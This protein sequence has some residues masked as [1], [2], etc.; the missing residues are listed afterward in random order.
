MTDAPSN[1]RESTSDADL[2]G[3]QLDGY[4]LIRRLARGAMA[5]VY[6]AHQE[7]LR[8]SVAVKVLKADLAKDA[9]YVK[10]FHNEAQAAASLVHANIVQI[11]SVG[12]ADGVHYIAQEYVQGQ[13][14]R[15]W[16]GRNGPADATAAVTIMRQVSAALQ[17]AAERGIVHRDIKPENIML[18]RTGEV[19]VADFGLARQTGDVAMNLTQIGVTMGTPLYMSPEQVEGRPLDPRSDLYSFGVTAYQMLSGMPPFRGETA[20]AIAV[21]HLKTPP[22]RIENLRPDLPPGLCRII[23]KLLAKDPQARYESAR[24]LLKDLHGLQL[25]G[26]AASWP[27]DASETSPEERNALASVGAA[28]ER[29]A[30]VMQ[31]SAQPVVSRRRLGMFSAALLLAFSAGGLAA[32]ALRAP[33]LL[34]PRA[35]TTVYKEKTAAD[36]FYHALSMPDDRQREAWLLSVPQYFNN[37]EDHTAMSRQYLAQLYLKEKR[38]AEALVTLEELATM[39]EQQFKRFKAFGLAG[40]AVVFTLQGADDKAAAALITLA[41]Y[42]DQLDATISPLV[43]EA[44]R[45]SRARMDEKQRSDYE[46]WSKNALGPADES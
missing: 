1:L 27:A 6:L 4:N 28:T 40:K 11:Y 14:L 22:E 7:S 41:P 25:T 46:E 42:R 35:A 34:T 9:S 29:L 36:Q 3:R 19:K 37:D 43:S 16:L 45:K 17:K 20:L 32:W 24:E 13:N 2:S 5:E 31:T 15:E 12:C 30:V 39:N 26:D 23:H 10:R 8:R 18:A 38:Y 21:Q 33:P 44:Y